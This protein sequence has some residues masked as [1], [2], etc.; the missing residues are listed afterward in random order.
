[1]EE[2][3]A[4]HGGCGG[5][6]GHQAVGMSAHDMECAR[7]VLQN[8]VT[9]QEREDGIVDTGIYLRYCNEIIH[10]ST[11]INQNE[12]SWFTEFGKGINNYLYS[13]VITCYLY[14]LCRYGKPKPKF[15]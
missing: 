7:V 13:T 3:P 2:A 6:C 15:C 9:Q 5:G 14:V 1:V 8:P 4:G 12:D 10:L 11:W